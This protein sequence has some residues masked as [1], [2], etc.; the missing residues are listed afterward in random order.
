VARFLFTTWEGGGHVQPMLLVA[1]GLR[2]LGHPS[3]VL[4]DACNADDAAALGLPF[5]PWSRAPSRTDR[6]PESDP[7][8]DWLASSPLQV[9]QGILKGVMC[10]P[11]AAYG[12]D[13]A[14]AIDAFGPDVVVSQELLFGAMAG[15]EAKG[16][17][18]AVLTSNLWSLP[19]LPDAPPFGGGLPPARGEEEKHAHRRV[20]GLTRQVFQAGLPALNEARAGLGLAPLADLFDQL[21]AAR[22]ILIATS[23]AFDFQQSPPEPYRYVGPYLADPAWTDDWTAPWPPGDRRLLVLVSFSTMYQRQEEPL[24]RVIAALGALPVRGIV[25]L[26]PVL[27]PSDFP[28]PQNVWVTAKAPHA[29]ILPLASAVVTHGGHATVLRPLMAG[30]PLVCMP[31]GRDQPDNVVRVTERFAGLKLAADASVTEIEIAIRT[32]LYEGQ[33]REAAKSFGGRIR[34]DVE[35]RSAEQE[36]L[37]VAKG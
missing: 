19:T 33:Y 16:R 7:V 28:A 2:D 31:L 20:A 21:G 3:L 10:G 23:R 1:Q 25:T 12:A 37:A 26:G 18:L 30:L 14:E 11:A 4:S 8:K 34:S 24:K 22:R 36:L 13:V 35:A 27:S 32:V 15:A 29:E 9:I 5:R 17:P 6:T